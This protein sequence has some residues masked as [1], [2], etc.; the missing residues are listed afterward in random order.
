MNEPR[1]PIGLLLRSADPAI[2]PDAARMERAMNVVHGEWRSML[3]SRKRTRRNWLSAAACVVVM[4]LAGLVVTFRPAAP[5]V[6][7]ATA[8]RVQGDVLLHAQPVSLGQVVMT[9]QQV[10]TGRGGRVLLDLV[11]GMRVRIDSG[12]VVQW[13]SPSELNLTRGRIYAETFEN[14]G[15]RTPPLVVK[16]PLGTV[17]HV[18]TRFEVQLASGQVRV[19]V[20]EGAV[21]FERRSQPAIR[22]AAGQQLSVKQNDAV[23]EAGP[24]AADDQWTWTREISPA[25]VIEGQPLAAALDSLS[26]EAGLAVVYR[27]E[28]AQL[29]A[30][31]L[32]LR[33]SIEGLDT[34]DALRA[35]LAG[36]GLEFELA[37]DRVEIRARRSE[38]DRR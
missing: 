17:R 30:R 20:R 4:L 31:A 16:T 6:A 35:V 25:F 33:G 2:E 26:H 13:I 24:G 15:A 1:D 29:Q 19:R 32:I 22:V 5:A 21:D 10:D 23:L 11:S 8:T 28:Q 36:S 27:D 18:G 12:S 34:R 14:T 7:V 37:S 9:Q 3:E 38:S